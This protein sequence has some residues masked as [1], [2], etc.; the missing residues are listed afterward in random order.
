MALYTHSAGVVHISPCSGVE[1]RLDCVAVKGDRTQ[2]IDPQT[3]ESVP[4]FNP[5]TQHWFDHFIWQPDGTQ[6]A[7]LTPCGRATVVALRLNNE[8]IV[9]TRRFWVEAGWWLPTG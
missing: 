6:I 2:A 7:G 9:E 3:G 8:H 4:L 1:S 5:R